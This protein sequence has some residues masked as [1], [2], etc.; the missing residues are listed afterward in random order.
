MARFAR[1]TVL[2]SMIDVG[3]VPVFH[4]GD[5]DTAKSIA[6][7]LSRG[8]A[9]AIEFTNRG[10][11][12]I[13][14]FSE[15]ERYCSLEHPDVIL[16]VGS[17]I[18]EVTAGAY[19]NLGAN[20]VVGPSLDRRVAEICNRRK[21]AYMPGCGSATEITLAHELGCEIVKVFPGGLVGGPAF[22]NAMRGPCPWTLA[23]PTGGVDITRSSL[24]SWFEAGVPCVG[25]GSKLVSKDLVES[26]DW[27]ALEQRTAETISNISNVR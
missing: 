19:I 27:D 5:P 6:A 17:V 13:E 21:V 15:L 26:A 14:T 12:A 2:N 24:E 22:V 8:G 23:M 18:D 3:L 7:A 4:N 11:H 16:G 20:F 9:R 25:I 10:D 1:L